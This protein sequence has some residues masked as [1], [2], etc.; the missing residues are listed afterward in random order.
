MVAVMWCSSEYTRVDPI[1]GVQ[2][3][4][5]QIARKVDHLVPSPIG[6]I[7]LGGGDGFIVDGG[8]EG[9]EHREAS[10]RCAENSPPTKPRAGDCA[11]WAS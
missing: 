10:E 2:F 7:A 4:G 1:M 3:A 11:H 9:A 8:A 5:P 6:D